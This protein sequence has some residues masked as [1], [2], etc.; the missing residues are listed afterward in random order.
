[1]ALAV[2]SG[3]SRSASGDVTSP[4]PLTSYADVVVDVREPT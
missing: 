1:M 2:R 3:A 4:L